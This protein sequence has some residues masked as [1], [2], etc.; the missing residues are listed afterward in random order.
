MQLSSPRSCRAG[1]DREFAGVFFSLLCFSWPPF[2]FMKAFPEC[3]ETP[4]VTACSPTWAAGLGLRSAGS[5]LGSRNII[6][7]FD[8]TVT[9][10]RMHSHA[11]PGPD[12]QSQLQYSHSS[13]HVAA[14]SIALPMCDLIESSH[15]LGVRMLAFPIYR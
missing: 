8:P 10:Q 15:T 11:C 13:F 9:V 12:L 2:C 7:S 3:E 14:P 6:T 1:E 5:S 4:N